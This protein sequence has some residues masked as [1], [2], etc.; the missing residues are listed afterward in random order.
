VIAVVLMSEELSW[1]V[2]AALAL[3]LGGVAIGRTARNPRRIVP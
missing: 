2:F 1:T 3:I